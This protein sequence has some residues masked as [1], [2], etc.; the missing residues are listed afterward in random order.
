MRKVFTF[1]TLC[2][3]EGKDERE[4]SSG[5][6]N[7]ILWLKHRSNLL[8]TKLH[9]LVVPFLDTLFLLGWTDWD[10]Q[11]NLLVCG[12]NDSIG[13]FSF[14]PNFNSSNL[15]SWLLFSLINHFSPRYKEID[16]V[17]FLTSE[18]GSEHKRGSCRLSW[19]LY[20]LVLLPGGTQCRIQLPTLDSTAR[21][22]THRTIQLSATPSKFTQF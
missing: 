12:K 9:N 7:S 13:Q 2:F 17:V 19:Q 5:K 18:N 15:R 3:T 16:G 4:N 8:Q 22:L 11:Y 14:F 20:R 10:Q 6:I 1:S 21:Y